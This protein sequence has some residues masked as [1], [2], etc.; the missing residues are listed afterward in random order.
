MGKLTEIADM[1]VS[2]VLESRRVYMRHRL[3]ALTDQPWAVVII[4]NH[5]NVQFECLAGDAEFLTRPTSSDRV[6]SVGYEVIIDDLANNIFSVWR[7]R[8]QTS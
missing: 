1:G 4:Y 7:A 6:F 5:Y 8:D 2:N 3:V